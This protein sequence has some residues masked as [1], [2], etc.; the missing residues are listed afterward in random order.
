[1]NSQPLQSYLLP[2]GG[3]GYTA[4][5]VETLTSFENTLA[6]GLLDES[7]STG[8]FAR[9]MELCQK[10]IIK[11]LRHSPRADNL[12][13]RHCH[14]GTN[15]REHHGWVPLGQISEDQYD[16]CYQ[17][18]G[19][20]A[21]Y[22][23]CD[24][25]IREMLDYAQKQAAQ[26]YLCNGIIYIMTDGRDL[27]STL[28]ER[29]VKTALGTAIAS[30][31]LESLITILI[32]VNDDASIQADLQKFAHNVGF[33]QYIPLKDA[34]EKSLAKL[35]NFISKSI[36]AQSQALGTGGPSQSLTF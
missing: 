6:L 8:S 29:D 22:D 10:E 21:L 14:F 30:E 18:G 1:M 4:A 20:T 2:G 27:G 7:G 12:I 13:Y 23:S 25:V 3:Y 36:S 35:A 5:P 16:G 28:R 31:A 24:R 34:S 17:P 19:Q 11:S 26:K 33:T 32:G 9:Q 15:F